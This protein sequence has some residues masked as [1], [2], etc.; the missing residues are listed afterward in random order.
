MVLEVMERITQLRERKEFSLVAIEGRS[1]SGKR[2][3]ASMIHEKMR[4]PVVHM[5]DFAL[6]PD[7]QPEEGSAEPAIAYERLTSEVLRPLQ[8]RKTVCYRTY[9]LRT[10]EEYGTVMVGAV[11]M[12][13]V[14]GVCSLHPSLRSFYDLKVFLD[15]D[16]EEQLRRLG[17]R[18]TPQAL[19]R[20]RS[21]WIPQEEQY[22]LEHDVRSAA[23]LYYIT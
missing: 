10:N 1:G 15:V 18:E 6:R 23:D 21:V 22:M 13:I 4:W 14:E 8:Q 12:V 17:G 5:D 16:K 9:N 7:E 11:P 19:E 20:F 3:L 2:A